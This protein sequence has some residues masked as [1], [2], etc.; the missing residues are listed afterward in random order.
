MNRRTA[1][2]LSIGLACFS[3]CRAMGRRS[4]EAPPPLFEG[5]GSH[6]R[7]ISTSS[8]AA[9]KYFNQGLVWAFAFN[10]DEA[11]RSFT[12]AARLD[13][14]CAMCWWGIAL[15]HGPHINNPTMDDK[16]SKAACD[17]VQKALSLVQHAS[18]EEQDLILALSKRYAY[19]TP[20][21][22]GP[23]DRAYADAMREVWKK[24]PKDVDVGV[25][26]AEAMM[27]LR[28]WDLWMKDGTP[29][30]G[31]EEIVAAL[32]DLL[33][34]SPEHPGALHLYIHAV[35]A[36]RHPDKALAAADRLRRL[37]PASGHLVHMPS[38]ID[39]LTGRW[40]EAVMANE[41][42]IEADREYRRISPR[43][44]FYH[45][46]MAH[47]HQMLS[48]AAMME[49][50]SELAID[51]ARAVIRGVPEDYARR[52]TAAIEP[53][54]PIMYEALVRFGKWDEILREPAP[55]DYLPITTALWRYS[56]AVALAAKGQVAEAERAHV[57]FRAARAKV[58]EGRMMAVN[59][60]DKILQIAEHMIAGEIAYRKGNIDE[61]VAELRKGIAVEDGLNYMEPPEWVQPVRHTLGAILLSAGRAEEAEQVYREDLRKWPENGWSLF[62]LAR[63]L[64]SQGKVA[65]GDGFE[66]RFRQAWSRSD[67]SIGSSC[68]C[69][70]GS[71]RAG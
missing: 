18:P 37:V 49:G 29:Q 44:G 68:L 43:Q 61:A 31:T 46:Y 21:D 33:Q 52:E 20:K 7:S 8:T 55:P 15:C 22:R 48:F 11:I 17:A 1:L 53:F 39:V 64:Q 4:A 59:P 63:S 28:P 60:A 12:E 34:M 54:I 16:R 58:P 6:A 70:P 62:G 47:N 23:F 13:P 66:Q 42:A 30:P 24:H 35:E 45:I 40:N 32:E 25:L 27:D 2:L 56:R 9:Q 69:V 51:A 38:H 3:G 14:Q 5:M 41:R 50:R 19:P 57:E 10:H 36:S 26:F 71:R 67:T 65:E